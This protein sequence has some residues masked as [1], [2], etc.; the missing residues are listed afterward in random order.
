MADCGAL[1][2]PPTY[3]LGSALP[4]GW[5]CAEGV[6]VSKGGDMVSAIWRLRTLRRAG[7][8]CGWRLPCGQPCGTP[9]SEVI[10]LDGELT[11]VCRRH[12]E[13]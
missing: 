9:A 4:C 8:R 12:E 11:A 7:Y 1:L 13:D 2:R 6:P 10:D 3:A 5:S